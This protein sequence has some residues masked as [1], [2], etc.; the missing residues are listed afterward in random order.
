MGGMPVSSCKSKIEVNTPPKDLLYLNHDMIFELPS[1]KPFINCS[2]PNHL[3]LRNRVTGLI[4]GR[5]MSCGGI[6]NIKKRQKT[7]S[8]QKLVEGV[9]TSQPDMNYKKSHSSASS[10]EEL[11]LLVTGGFSEYGALDSTEVFSSK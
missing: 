2:V 1:F 4:D 5:I 9:W 10:S 7:K 3:N 11:G 6:D 8:C